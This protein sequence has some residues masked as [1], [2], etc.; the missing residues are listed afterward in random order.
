M[1]CNENNIENENNIN[2]NNND[3]NIEN[4]NNNDNDKIKCEI[5]IQNKKKTDEEEYWRLMYI[6]EYGTEE[7][8][9]QYQDISDRIPADE[10]ICICL[11]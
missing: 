6:E 4:D 3:N 1:N 11:N 7:E 8:Q 10:P 2:D 9:K 5:A